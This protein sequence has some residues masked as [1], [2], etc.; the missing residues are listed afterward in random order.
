M[1]QDDCQYRSDDPVCRRTGC[2]EKSAQAQVDGHH[3]HNDGYEAECRSASW[4]VRNLLRRSASSGDG[5]VRLVIGGSGLPPGDVRRIVV[6]DL[7]H[8]CGD[9]VLDAL[10]AVP[11]G[12]FD[13]E[14]QRI[15]PG[16]QRATASD[17][18]DGPVRVRPFNVLDLRWCRTAVGQAWGTA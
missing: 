15:R 12:G 8:A 5:T 3:Q 7:L 11:V 16:L 1:E 4:M 17:D 2:H 10:E 13:T 18:V 9:E 14:S 6:A